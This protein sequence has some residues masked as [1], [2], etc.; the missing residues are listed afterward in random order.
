MLG[1]FAADAAVSLRNSVAV[2]RC[3]RFQQQQ[4]Q[5]FVLRFTGRNDATRRPSNSSERPR[6][7]QREQE[8][9]QTPENA[10]VCVDSFWMM[11]ESVSATRV[12]APHQTG[13]EDVWR[14]SA[15]VSIRSNDCLQKRTVL[16]CS[17]TLMSLSATRRSSAGSRRRP[18]AVSSPRLS[19][20]GDSSVRSSYSAPSS[21]C[22][23]TESSAAPRSNPDTPRCKRKPMFRSGGTM[24]RSVIFAEVAARSFHQILFVL[25]VFCRRQVKDVP[26]SENHGIRPP[27]P[28]QYLTPLQQKEVCIR[29]LRARLRENVERLQDRDSEIEELRTQLTQMQEEWIEEECHRIEAQLALKEARKEIRQ[30]QQTVETVRSNL[31]PLEGDHQDCRSRLGASRSCGCSPAHTMGRSATFTRLSTDAT[32]R[33]GSVKTDRYIP[34]NR[35]AMTLPRGNARTHLLLEAGSL[36]EQVPHVSLSLSRSSTC[37]RLCNAETVLPL[38]RSCHAVNCTP[39][40]Y[41]PHHHLYLHLPQEEAPAPPSAPEVNDRPGYRSQACSPTRTWISEERGVQDLSVIT[42]APDV[43]PAE[44]HVLSQSSATTSPAQTSYITET[45]PL[46]TA[47]PTVITKPQVQQPSPR[48]SPAVEIQPQEVKVEEEGESSLPQR[49]H[50]SRYFLVDLLAVAVPVV[51]TLAWLCRGTRNEG[52]PMYNM[53]SLLRGC[54][55]VALH[56]LR[57]VGSAASGTGSATSIS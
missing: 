48:V 15:R 8:P 36:S 32:E 21:S 33:N 43:T 37:E 25:A 6:I 19:H 2:S 38:S 52:I 22:R 26:C 57:R 28:E 55:A 30:L 16:N 11:S 27:A 29:H 34:A 20:G 56:S 5:R 10:C 9:P 13:A 17:Q 45:L 54:C 23:C 47:T 49:G 39:H 31:A 12:S 46:D 53:G 42:C 18:A 14:V 41:V 3:S 7:P 24:S 4:H 44:L 50:W 51:P 40:A 1:T 35:G